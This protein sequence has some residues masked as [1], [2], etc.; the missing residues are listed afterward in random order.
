MN[1]VRSSRSM[2]RSHSFEESTGVG[3][4]DNADKPVE[5]RGALPSVLQALEESEL[6]GRE[7]AVYDLPQLTGLPLADCFVAI[8]TLEF[9]KLA[10]LQDDPA[11]PF[12]AK[13]RLIEDGRKRLS[14]LK[15]GNAA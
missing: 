7:L 6:R 8:R 9:E 2:E 3:Q 13:L 10:Q 15:D 4:S 12:G 5:C 11:D 14:A 1:T